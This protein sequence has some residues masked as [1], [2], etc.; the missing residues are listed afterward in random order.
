MAGYDTRVSF[1]LFRMN[2]PTFSF[3]RVIRILIFV[4]SVSALS[5]CERLGLE[6]HVCTLIGCSSGITVVLENKPTSPYRIEV[7][8]GNSTGPRYVFQCD[9]QTNCADPF[10]FDYTPDHVFVDV[11]VGSNRTTY[12]VVPK[13]TESRP[14]GADCEPLCRQSTIRLPSDQLR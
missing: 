9:A 11:V 5:S 6:P 13:Y 7:Y 8:S 12:E 3:R 14:N 4:F 2:K 1:A 10:F